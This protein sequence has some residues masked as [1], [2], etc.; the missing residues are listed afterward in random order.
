MKL[1]IK[2]QYIY[3]DDSVKDKDFALSSDE[4]SEESANEEESSNESSS[5]NENI[6]DIGND[7]QV[8]NPTNSVSYVVWS[9]I[10][11]KIFV[12]RCVYYKLLMMAVYN[13]FIL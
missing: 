9:D 5:E 13:S 6:N 7:V 4:Q 2:L 1:M 10:I 3:S 12:P 8:L 11:S